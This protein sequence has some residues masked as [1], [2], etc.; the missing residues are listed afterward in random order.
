MQPQHAPFTTLTESNIR[1]LLAILAI[2]GCTDTR[3]LHREPLRMRCGPALARI[4]DRAER[5]A[6]ATKEGVMS[7]IFEV[8]WIRAKG[9]VGPP[10]R[11]D[12][13]GLF[14]WTLMEN[15]YAG[16]GSEKGRVL[17][18]VEFGLVCVRR[19]ANGR[20]NGVSEHDESEINGSTNGHT[21]NGS[22]P[23]FTAT[24]GTLSRN[25]LLKPKVLLESV[26]EIL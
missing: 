16:H 1:G 13:D 9:A 10:R 5:L 14:D 6:R 15:V 18:T 24:D 25:L 8:T 11:H 17:C 23:V 4:A 3:G 19:A 26:A 7:G 20:S 22:G 12:K 21:T 2:S